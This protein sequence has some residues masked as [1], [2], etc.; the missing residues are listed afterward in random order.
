M[1]H[2]LIPPSNR[3]LGKIM[4]RR[5]TSAEFKLWQKLRERRLGG[6][7]FRRQAPLGLY[8]VDFFCAEHKLVVEVDGDQ[9]GRFLARQADAQRDEWIRT[10]GLTVLRV[11]NRDVMSNIEGVCN[12]IVAT[13]SAGL[14]QSSADARFAEDW[15]AETNTTSALPLREGR[16][17]RGEADSEF[18]EG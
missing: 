17:R 11:S 18:G 4:R 8:I 9:H 1:P 5:L 12:A 16:I 3:R 13:A 15:S 10:Q 6:L 2:Q 14:D 7:R